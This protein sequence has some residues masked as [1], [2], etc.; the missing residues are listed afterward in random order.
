MAKPEF[1]F[2]PVN[3]PFLKV[4]SED[5]NTTKEVKMN[6]DGNLVLGSSEIEHN[7]TKYEI[8]KIEVQETTSNNYVDLPTFTISTPKAGTYL[9]L[10]SCVTRNSNKNAWTYV[11]LNQESTGDVAHSERRAEG[12]KE[13]SLDTQAVITVSG[14]EYIKVRFKRD[15][16]GKAEISN[17]NLVAVR[18]G[19]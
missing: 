9:V 14:S 13:T 15:S 16:N 7:T 6:D 8:T 17:A 4:V 1:T 2:D 12:N 11:V 10:F 18:L 3:G 5:G 19:D